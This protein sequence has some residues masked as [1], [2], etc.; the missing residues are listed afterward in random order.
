MR[1][2]AS[3]DEKFGEHTPVVSAGT[4][5]LVVG[6]SGA[7]KDALIEAAR[8]ALESSGQFVFIEREVNRSPHA[9]ERHLAISDA[10]FSER[11]ARA[12]YA[13]TWAAHGLNYG[14]P[15]LLDQALMND[16][17]AIF[18]ASRSIIAVARQRYGRVRVVLVDCPPEVRAARLAARGRELLAEVNSR[19]QRA[20]PGFDAQDADVVIDN[21][22]ALVTSTAH[23]IRELEAF[24]G[25][26][27]QSFKA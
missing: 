23:F 2:D 10:T 21:S 12:E 24:A 7:G 25:V 17:V 6:P 4:L 9:A 3:A 26:D 22:G 15:K 13:L 18:N 16:K 27:D 11:L 5:V 19:L 14:I 8:A 1:G 20:V